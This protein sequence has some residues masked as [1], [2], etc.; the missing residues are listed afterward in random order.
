MMAPTIGE[1]A[2]HGHPHHR[3]HRRPGARPRAGAR[4]ARRHGARPRPR[5]GAPGRD[6][7]GARRGRPVRGYLA[8]LAS[9][10]QVRRLAAEIR[11][12]E[13]RLDA[14]VSN[15]GLGFTDV[16]ELSEDGLEL[17]FAVNFLAGWLL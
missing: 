16:R 1:D 2:R 8:D 7:R 3:C 11:E 6:D 5:P 9:L 4:R 17:R 14:L 15:A 12:A 13:P 10:T